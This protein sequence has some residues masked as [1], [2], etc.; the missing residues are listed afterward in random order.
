V[1]IVSIGSKILWGVLSDRIGREMTYAMGITCSII[2][3]IF[4][5]L[6]DYRPSPILA[7]FFAT[8]FGMG[9]AVTAALPPLITADFFEGRAYGSIFGS[10]MIFIGIGGA[11]GAWFAGFLY[12]QVGNYLPVFVILIGCA[13]FSS[14]NIWWAAPRRIR[15]VPGKRLN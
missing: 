6:I 10:L 7:Y 11:L 14:L 15:R 3:I 12:D 5:I 2:G 8:F 9:Y 13:L 4:L 1:G